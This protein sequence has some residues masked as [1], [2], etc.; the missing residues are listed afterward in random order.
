MNEHCCMNNLMDDPLTTKIIDQA[1]M[2]SN[3]R[4]WTMLWL[5]M[6]WQNYEKPKNSNRIHHGEEHTTL[7]IFPYSSFE[8]R[9]MCA[10]SSL[11]TRRLPTNPG[12]WSTRS[13]KSPTKIR[14]NQLHYEFT[15]Q[16]SINST[17]QAH[18]LPWKYAVS[19]SSQDWD[20]WQ[21]P[22]SHGNGCSGYHRLW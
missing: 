6:G 10:P 21:P 7:P 11:S 20:T 17:S 15:T 19:N 12:S 1:R 5:H 8:T 4:V 2:I 13:W 22:P 14:S 3:T 9:S 16:N 18:R